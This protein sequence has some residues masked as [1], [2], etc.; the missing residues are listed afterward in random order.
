MTLH[1]FAK[2]KKW[3]LQEVKVHVDYEKKK[4]KQKEG[5]TIQQ[6]VITKKI[7]ILGNLDESQVKRLV[8]IGDRCPI[9]KTLH[10]DVQISS[11]LIS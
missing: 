3:D 1:V 10:S 7:E 11:E 9:H 6:D 4:V 2:H 8:E 5:N